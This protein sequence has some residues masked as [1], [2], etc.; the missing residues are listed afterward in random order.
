MSAY[1]KSYF[2]P[3]TASIILM[4]LVINGGDGQAETPA[5]VITLSL[6]VYASLRSQSSASTNITAQEKKSQSEISSHENLIDFVTIINDAL[7]TEVESSC[8]ELKQARG[9][10]GDAVS[11]L[12]SSFSGL[13]NDIQN[14]KGMVA[15]L[16]DN[17]SGASLKGTGDNDKAIGIKEF[18]NETSEILTYFIDL[19]VNVSKQSIETVHKIDDMVYQMDEIFKLLEDIKTIAD[20][21]S[22]LALNAA[23]EAAHAG[24]AGRGFAVVADEVRKLS[25]H[26]NKFNDEIRDH[27]EKTRVSIT[28]ARRIVGDVASK[29][30]NMAISAKSRVDMMLEEVGNMNSRVSEN[31][32]EVSLISDNINNNVNQAVRG[33]QFEDIVSQ[34]IDSSQKYLEKLKVFSNDILGSISELDTIGSDVTYEASINALKSK[35][36][37]S[38]SKLNHERDKPAHQESIVEGEVELF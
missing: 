13:N 32:C 11:N 16:I 36:K 33:L 20:Q 29:D 22:L 17:V 4:A 21:T 5:L 8:K 10:I 34:Q 12:G 37:D 2:V 26:S 19:L 38:R 31:L 6:W 14:Q 15:S 25:Q 18:A 27:V 30:M 9:V 28:D 23:I 7:N 3:L 35:L 24:E 1:L